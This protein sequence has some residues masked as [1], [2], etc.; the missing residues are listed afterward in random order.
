M[1]RIIAAMFCLSPNSNK[2]ESSAFF[3]QKTQQPFSGEELKPSEGCTQDPSKLSM[4][5]TAEALRVAEHQSL[6]RN[7]EEVKLLIPSHLWGWN[8]G[9][10]AQ[11]WGKM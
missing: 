3:K 11:C 6:S 1:G 9:V 10:L 4:C 5:R 7:R 8:S 2:E